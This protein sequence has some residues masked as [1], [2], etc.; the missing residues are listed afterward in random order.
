MVV[1]FAVKLSFY[2]YRKALPL[3]ECEILATG[4]VTYRHKS[5]DLEGKS[6][7][8]SCLEHLS[9][10]ATDTD[11]EP[12]DEKHDAF[13]EIAFDNTRLIPRTAEEAKRKAKECRRQ[14]SLSENAA[15]LLYNKRKY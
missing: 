1:R 8:E 7:R 15:S 14:R 4:G 11:D 10:Y 9:A 12:N 2:T 5:A 3:K 6:V 13:S